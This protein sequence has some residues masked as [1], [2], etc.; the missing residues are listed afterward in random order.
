MTPARRPLLTTSALLGVGLVAASLLT[1]APARAVGLECVWTGAGADANWSTSAN[2]ADCAGA[3]P[4]ED[5]HLTFPDGPAVL[6]TTNDL[7]GV[8]L[9]SVDV[10]G[11]GYSITG[12]PVRTAGFSVG[13]A[14]TMDADLQLVVPAGT[15]AFPI[16][17]D[18]SFG[19]LFAIDLE[20]AAGS[21][22][23]FVLA[24][25]VLNARFTGDAETL[26]IA[27]SGTVELSNLLYPGA[28]E[29]AG[30]VQ[31]R[32]G[33]PVTCGGA[34]DPLALLDGSSLLLT[35]ATTFPRPV[36]IASA[37][38]PAVDANG[39]ALDFAHPVTVGATAVVRGGPVGS[40]LEFTGGLS[41]GSH[42]LTVLGS[43]TVPG[44]AQVT[45]APDATLR[46]GSAAESGALVIDE[47]QLGH[48]GTTEVTGSGSLLVADDALA[49]GPVPSAPTIVSAGA[50]LGTNS[51]ISL[52]ESL[53]V[54][55]GTIA[56]LT[57]GA[58]LMLEDVAFG[59]EVRFE[60]RASASSLVIENLTGGA[61][62]VT[63]ASFGSDAPII[64]DSTGV[65]AHTGTTVAATGSVQLDRDLAIPGEFVIVDAAVTTLHTNS[66][67]LHDLIA[68]TAGVTFT[69]AGSFVLNDNEAIRSLTGTVG[70]LQFVAAESGLHIV[71]ADAT[72]FNG[73]IV[74]G[75]TLHHEGSGSLHL[76]ADWTVVAAGSDLIVADGVVRVDGYLPLTTATVQGELRGVG[77]VRDL[78]LDGGRLAAGGSPGCFTALGDLTG[79]GE[80][81]AEIGG[82][83]PCTEFDRIRPTT[84]NLGTVTWVPVLVGG[85]T[86]TIG[87]E[88][89][90]IEAPDGGT[91]ITATQVSAGGVHFDVVPDGAD[92]LLR[93]VSIPSGGGGLAVT[94][95]ETNLLP[96]GLALLALGALLVAV[97]VRAGRTR[98]E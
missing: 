40:E 19:A 47:G 68:D 24:G 49:L 82:D 46:V 53:Q 55:G 75:G 60:T 14:T 96:V 81:V 85:F 17:G 22:A 77:A 11:A 41:L 74:G 37:A 23:E 78:V 63:L 57:S 35:A 83:T 73:E 26:R 16:A 8:T 45:S 71:G 36:T 95:A 87:D 62:T 89:R 54:A 84:Q 61:H 43:A 64:I 59:G 79:S 18:L 66:A 25:A 21:T 94:G 67:D 70:T 44:F 10:A 6:A 51:V 31:L 50:V 58:S 92:V 2:W 93:V 32:C 86:P 12:S 20:Q 5:D 69:G 3:A 39:F 34:G 27:G 13:G 88:F 15:T 48:L 97:R 52:G 56:A 28:V 29:V 7:V 80:I 72:A 98:T 65:S 38:S 30:D 9:A 76:L 90:I 42:D 1:A 33:G 91:P 4:G